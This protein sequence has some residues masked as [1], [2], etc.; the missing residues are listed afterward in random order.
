MN[1]WLYMDKSFYGEYDI[2]VVDALM[3]TLMCGFLYATCRFRNLS[4]KRPLLV[5]EY[6]SK[7]AR[8]G[9]YMEYR[10]LIKFHWWCGY[11]CH[12]VFLF[13]QRPADL[14]LL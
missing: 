8:Q 11:G 3:I 2:V 4:E 1:A 14:A 10:K 13:P 7:F 6:A 5:A 9:V 12:Y